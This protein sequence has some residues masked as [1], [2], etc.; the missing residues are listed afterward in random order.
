M[1]SPSA[2]K[3][4]L[5]RF[6]FSDLSAAKLLPAIVLAQASPDDWVLCQITS[7][8]SGDPLAIRIENSD[9]TVGSLQRVSFARPGKLFTAN[10]TLMATEVGSLK[11]EHFKAVIAAVAGLLRRG[12]S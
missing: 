3:V 5:V 1:V 2:G 11:K 4:V 6:P 12:L 9:F 7:T 10:T 8:T